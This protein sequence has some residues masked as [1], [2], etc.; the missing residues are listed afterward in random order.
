MRVMW[1]FG[2]L[3]G[4]ASVGAQQ[5]V[6]P[7]EGPSTLHRLGLT[8]KDT[9][10]GSASWAEGDPAANGCRDSRFDRAR[11][12]HGRRHLSRELPALPHG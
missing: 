4:G 9:N 8:I 11:R 1:V 2:F 3:L 5:A 12:P 10:L 7:V 6:T